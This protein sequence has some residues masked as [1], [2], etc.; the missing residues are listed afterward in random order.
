MPGALLALALALAAPAPAG[1]AS[2]R[3]VAAATT[4]LG[5]VMVVDGVDEAAV[6]DAIAL[7]LPRLALHHR[8]SGAPADDRPGLHAYIEVRRDSGD[9]IALTIILADGRAFRRVLEADDADAPRAIAG[10]LA[11]LIPAI[12]EA[13]IEADEEDVPLPPAFS[14]EL[15]SP[16][17]EPEPEPAPE[18]EPE[19]EPAPDEGSAATTPEPADAGAPAPDRPPPLELGLNLGSG[20]LV[21]FVPPSA[22]WRGAAGWLGLELRWRRG[23]LL[24]AELRLAGV[25]APDVRLLRLRSA[26]GVG[27]G[28]RRG[29]FEVPIVALLSVEPWWVRGPGGPLSP[30]HAADGSAARPLLGLGVRLSPGYRVELGGGRLSLRIGVRLEAMTSGE[31][32]AGLRRPVLGD[33]LTLGGLELAGGLDLTLWLPASSRSR[34]R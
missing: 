10:A 29:P 28:L 14:A 6:R 16:A 26:L 33:A 9:A 23:L 15:G 27:Y 12:E 34:A 31:P 1:T 8:E 5:G 2:P 32:R 11:S 4:I 18:P 17:P 13:S 24:G 22:G 21:G 19:P 30:T 3:E 25:S 20:G 7:R